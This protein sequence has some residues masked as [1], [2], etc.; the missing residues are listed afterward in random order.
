MR[1]M[2][3]YGWKDKD[4]EEPYKISYNITKLWSVGQTRTESNPN[5]Q[6]NGSHNTSRIEADDVDL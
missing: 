2:T 4:T 5:H 6:V 3:H 1:T